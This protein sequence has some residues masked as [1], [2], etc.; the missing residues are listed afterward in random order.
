MRD[1]PLIYEE[2]CRRVPTKGES[3]VRI[4]AFRNTLL[5]LAAMTG[6]AFLLGSCGGGG[7]TSGSN[8]QTGGII[9]LLPATG[10]AYAGV[11]FTMTMTG[12]RRPYTLASSEPSL[13]PVP[14]MVDGNS[15]T[16][17][18]ANPG[19]IDSGLKPEDLP[20]RTVNITMRDASAQ[21][22]TAVIKVGIN[23]LTGYGIGLAPTLCP[24]SSSGG[25]AV[26]VAACA[27]GITALQ[28]KSVFQGNIY[29]GRSFTFQVI[30]GNFALKNVETGQSS[31]SVTTITD[32]TGMALV[33]VEVPANAP[34]QLAVVRV[35]DTAT[36][37]YA[38]EVF[39]ITGVPGSGPGSSGSL[40]AI[41]TD[42]TF[43]GI[44]TTDCGVG[45]SDILIYDG[46]PPYTATSVTPV[47]QVSPTTSSTQP[48]RF[49]ISVNN[50]N[51]C[52][53]KSPV[54]VTDANGR[55]VTVNVTTSPGSGT[56]PTPAA[57]TVGPTTVTLNCG[58]TS[59]ASAAGGSGVYTV[60]ST[61]PRVQATVSGGVIGITRLTGDGATLYPVTGTV[62]V[63]DGTSLQPISLTV[64]ANCP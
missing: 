11:P 49:T 62:T 5:G 28:M 21:S 4:R 9:A 50:S 10:S 42:V 43:T 32:H 3:I 35:I 19:V 34:T 61:H 17:V 56:P 47:V 58:L 23:F 6:A 54:V 31:S 2:F 33:F 7:A 29:G 41:P 12:G 55:R 22:V 8:A 18:P 15:F 46:Q 39:T 44:L 26:A 45:S 57:F 30:R 51:V 24:A 20:I 63:S 38:D 48:G 36:G 64:P 60:T 16:T 14:N 1:N 40:T 13:F 27:G 53:N 25:T 52:L 59:N 37:V